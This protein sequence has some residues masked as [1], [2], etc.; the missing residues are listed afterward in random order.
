MG[1]DGKGWGRAIIN[2]TWKALSFF[3]DQPLRLYDLEADVYEVRDQASSFPDIVQ[4][5]GAWGDS[6]HV[7]QPDFPVTNCVGS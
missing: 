5:L 7:D 4:A 1:E 3:E 6:Q 2:G